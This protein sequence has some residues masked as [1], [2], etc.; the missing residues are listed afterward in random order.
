[1]YQFFLVEINGEVLSLLNPKDGTSGLDQCF[2]T[3]RLAMRR[4]RFIQGEIVCILQVTNCLSFPSGVMLNSYSRGV[5]VSVLLTTEFMYVVSLCQKDCIL[6]HC[7]SAW[8]RVGLSALH[9][10]HVY[11]GFIPVVCGSCVK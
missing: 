10:G 11:L 9:L 5:G 1:M 3:L 6:A 4:H 2:I 7:H 8:V